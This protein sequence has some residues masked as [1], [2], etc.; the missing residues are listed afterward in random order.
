[1]FNDT[2]LVYFPENETM[3]EIFY[4]KGFDEVFKK[5]VEKTN[6]P[7]EGVILLARENPEY[8][9]YLC[10]LGCYYINQDFIQRQKKLEIC[11]EVLYDKKRD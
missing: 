7:A 9:L 1:M 8:L 2:E 10:A 11:K 3:R 6:N 5:I 4:S